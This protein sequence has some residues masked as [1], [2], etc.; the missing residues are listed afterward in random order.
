MHRQPMTDRRE[1]AEDRT[2]EQHLER[3]NQLHDQAIVDFCGWMVSIA[4]LSIRK[5]RGS[6]GKLKGDNF[7]AAERS[8]K[9]PR[10]IPV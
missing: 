2:M 9:G 7:G 6:V 4:M 1:R 8:I 10:G 3:G 5:A